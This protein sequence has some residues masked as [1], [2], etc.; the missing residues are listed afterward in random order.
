MSAPYI[1]SFFTELGALEFKS[2]L[3]A[4]QDPEVA[5][6]PVPRQISV[7]CGTGVRF[8]LDFDPDRM[9]NPDLDSIYEV[10]AGGYRLLWSQDEGW[11][12]GAESGDQDA[13]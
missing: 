6:M 7:S 9:N 8:S 5:M 12:A 3:T 10:Q 2:C 1:A 11:Q 4:L 13:R